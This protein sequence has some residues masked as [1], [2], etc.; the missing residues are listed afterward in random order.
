MLFVLPAHQRAGV[1]RALLDILRR[2]NPDSEFTVNSSPNAVSAYQRFGFEATGPETATSGI[3]FVPMRLRALSKPNQLPDPTSPS[4]TRPAGQDTRHPSPRIIRTF[5]NNPHR[6]TL[7]PNF[8]LKS[9][10]ASGTLFLSGCEVI[11]SHGMYVGTQCPGWD[12]TH[13]AGTGPSQVYTANNFKYPAFA[14]VAFAKRGRER[15]G[16]VFHARGAKDRISSARNLWLSTMTRTNVKRS[17][18]RQR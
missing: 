10:F 18:C 1:G 8:A 12:N 13:P 5:D 4:V 17:M 15:F 7:N 14:S 6:L 9:V 2:E 16:W 3:R 11:P